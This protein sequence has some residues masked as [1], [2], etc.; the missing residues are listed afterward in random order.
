MKKPVLTKVAQATNPRAVAMERVLAKFPAELLALP[1]WV[2]WKLERRDDN[3]TKIPYQPNGMKADSTN[4]ATWSDFQTVVRAFLKN[5]DYSGVGFVFSANDSYVGIDLDKCRDPVTGDVE[6]WAAAVLGRISTYT[7]L[8]PSGTGFHLLGKGKLPAKGRRKDHIEMYD[9]GRYF[10]VTGEHYGQSPCD[11]VDIQ[12]SLTALH[13]EVFRKGAKPATRPPVASASTLA[14]LSGP[15]PAS[16]QTVVDKVLAS[17]DADSFRQF[18]AGNWA[19]LDYPSQS[20]GDLALAGMLARHVGPHAEQIDRLFRSTGMMRDKWDEMRGA[21]TYGEMTIAKALENA[22]AD[23]AAQA[24]VARMNHQFAVITN[25]NQVKILAEGPGDADF[26]LLSK[27]D[28]ELLTCNLPSPQANKT[29]AALWLRSP[30][31][32]A[33]DS[34]VFWPGNDVA[35]KYNLWRGFSVK[36]QQG[37]CS[38]FWQFVREAI[39][40]GSDE[41][42]AYVRCYFA[43]MVQRPWERPEVAIV[44]RG[45]QGTGKNTFVDAMG[46]LVKLHFCEVSSVD[47]LTGRFNAHM[48]N[49]ILM[50]ANEATWGGNKSESGKLKAMITDATIP[51]EMK[52]QDILHIDNFLRLVVSSN[53][54]WPVPVDAD[55]RRFLILDVSSV[56][57]QDTAFFAALHAELNAGGREALM[58]DLETEDLTGFSPRDKPATPFG[59]DMKIRSADSPTRWLYEALSGNAWPHNGLAIFTASNAATMPKNSL[60]EDYQQWCR[61]MSERFPMSRD[62]FFKRVRELLGISMTDS[63][64]SAPSGQTRTREVVFA[65]IEDCRQAFAANAGIAR[66]VVW[67]SM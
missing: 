61:S 15:S 19:A 34:L 56:F 49:I 31:R 11:A 62:H 53:E 8:S 32:R 27:T 37:D 22:A 40:A 42:Y 25:S 2:L 63:R 23:D 30:D 67:D 54:S 47:Q 46:S 12:A 55:D 58:H 14:A 26:R 66:S 59:A 24:F 57:K 5:P 6:P 17:R 20:E 28:F 33:Y 7:E 4:R 48:R 9:S 3:T 18:Q 1:Q 21:N 29:A 35:G 52:G 44:L 50:H 16:D 51:V 60:A 65:G 38:L 36:A 10:T 39:C 13:A 64:P 41:I 43:H 45:G